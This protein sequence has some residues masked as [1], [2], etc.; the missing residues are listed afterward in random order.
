MFVFS[1]QAYTAASGLLHKLVGTAKHQQSDA[2]IIQFG[3]W[4]VMWRLKCYAILAKCRLALTTV[5]LLFEC[6]S[7]IA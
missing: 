5:V 3:M 6:C 4:W 7:E 2:I 1:R